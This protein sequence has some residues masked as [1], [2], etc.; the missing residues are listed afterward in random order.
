MSVAEK[1]K[2]MVQLG[3]RISRM[4]DFHDLWA[5]SSVF[6][7]DGPTLRRA[8][9]ACFERRGT[10]WTGDEPDALRASMYL[11][12]VL[13][14][15]WRAYLRAGAFQAPPPESFA[16]IGERVRAFLGPVRASI[17]G[18]KAFE[19]RWDPDEGWG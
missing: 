10:P 11:V 2:A 6:A 16:V 3:R 17:V 8:V 1:F 14:T 12:P 18:E 7:F 19:L 9:V 15:R 5:L 4:K 13:Q